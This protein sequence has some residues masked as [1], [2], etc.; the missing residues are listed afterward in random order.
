M[1]LD[2]IL[3]HSKTEYTYTEKKDFKTIKNNIKN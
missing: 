2:I 3:R 1:I